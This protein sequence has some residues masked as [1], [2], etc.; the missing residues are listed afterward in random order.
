MKKRI[1]L[2]TIMAASAVAVASF[3]KFQEKQKDQPKPLNFEPTKVGDLNDRLPKQ[4]EK[5]LLSS[6]LLESYR[7]QCQVMMDAYPEG[8][9]LDVL[10]HL[11]AQDASSYEQLRTV[12][13]GLRLLYEEKP[14]QN[15][16]VVKETIQTKAQEAYDAV[17]EMASLAYR[18]NAHYQGWIFENCN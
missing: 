10:H 3:K 7:V 1:A 18:E 11:E 9:H 5:S 8:K 14:D 13:R 6:T 2:L 12:L 17:V 16:F 15:A 4:P